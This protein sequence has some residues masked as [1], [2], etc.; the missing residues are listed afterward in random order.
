MAKQYYNPENLDFLLFDVHDVEKLSQHDY[1]REFQ[2]ESIKMMIESARQIA[3]THLFPYLV[4]MDRQGVQF[5]NGIPRIHSK[6]KEYI[7]ELGDG[8]W[9]GATYTYED[10]GMQLP[11][12]VQSCAEFIYEAA[13]NSAAGYYLLTAGAAR[14]ITN[15]GTREQHEQY[16]SKMASGKWQGTMCLTEPQAGSSLSDITTSATPDSNGSYNIRGQKIY[17]S[18]GDHDGAENFVHLML[19]RIDGAPAGTKGIS[20]FIVP[21]FREENGE[22]VFNDVTTASL[23]HKMGQHAY[24][25]TH[26][27]IGEKE[28]C[29][30]WLVGEPNKGLNYMFQMMNEARIGVGISGAAIASAAYY[31]SLEYAKERPQGRKIENKD[32]NVS[33][34]YIIEHADVRR[35]LFLQ[36]AIVEGSLSLILECSK[37]AD[38][39]KV[40]E[41]EERKHYNLLLELLTPVVKTYPTEAGINS[42]SNGV[43]VLGGAGYC[44][45]FPL[46]QLYRDIRITAIYEG[47]TGIQSMDL[48]GRKV[49][50]ED[51]KAMQLF[52]G[53]VTE[54]IKRVENY[55]WFEEQS[56]TLQTNIDHLMT[57]TQKM[58]Q[59]AMKGEVEKYLADANLYMEY[60][61]LIA[62]AWQWLKQA[63]VAKE[64]L[65]EGSATRREFLESKIHTMK[66]YFS[67]ELNKTISL[68]ARLNHPGEYLTIK[69]DK[70]YL[71]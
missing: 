1:F 69:T 65:E 71:I 63:R 19:A 35:M 8:G 15:F 45:D 38:L 21:K 26:L 40:A 18:A 4:E 23:F 10:G 41:G 25:T 46:E 64:K 20:L 39:E 48:L 54:E 5:E 60:F 56:H 12:M 34:A 14:L 51:G 24:A 3:D 61:S 52:Y 33:P 62:I 44:A 57:L 68:F 2:K 36:K 6:I 53:L 70:E 17:I 32:P 67:Y 58:A 9:I 47:T 27:M 7:A 50:M 59:L 49:L 37:W 22:L 55:G 13:N 16:V 29:R 31:A 42:V 11:H 43:Q 28:D 30:G 66:F